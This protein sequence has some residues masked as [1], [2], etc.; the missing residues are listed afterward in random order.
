MPID[1]MFP[2][3]PDTPPPTAGEYAQKLER[4]LQYAYE[5][6]RTHLKTAAQHNKRLYDRRTHGQGFTEGD[7]VWMLNKN[8]KKGVTPKFQPNWL[9]P[10]IILHMHNDVLAEVKLSQRRTTT[11]HTD[12]LKP[13]Y[14]TKLPRWL[15]QYRA[16][17][18]RR[19]PVL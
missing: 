16:R 10:S 11:V 14:S 1:L 4:K 15:N 6:T 12:M 9:G 17:L 5:L 2:L 8:R 7:L 18:A 13:C 3:P 19:P